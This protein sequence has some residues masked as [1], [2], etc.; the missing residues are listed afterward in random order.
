MRHKLFVSAFLVLIVAFTVSIAQAA[1]SARA[2]SSTFT[3]NST[4]DATDSNPGDDICETASGNGVCTLR[5]AIQ[6]TNALP[7]DD[8]IN[9]PAGS[10]TVTLTGMQEDG[11]ATGDFD[12]ADNVT[13]VGAGSA[14][15]IINANHLDRIFHIVTS[16]TVDLSGLT[17]KNGDSGSSSGGGILVGGT[18]AVEP[19]L[20]LTDVAVLNNQTSNEGG[21]IMNWFGTLMMTNVVVISNTATG[22]GAGINNQGVFTIT[23]S[24]IMSNVSNYRGGGIYTDRFA[25]SIISNTI[26]QSNFANLDGGGIYIFN[27]GILTLDS[28]M[29][30][31]NASLNRG[32][33]IYAAGPLTLTNST[34]AGNTAAQSGGGIGYYAYSLVILN[35]TISSNRASL[36]GGGVSGG[37]ELVLNNA[38]ITGNYADA[39][40]NGSGDGGGVAF[41]FGNSEI[42]NTIIAGNVDRGGEA[43]DCAGTLT[44]QDYNLIQDTTGCVL[45]GTV[46]HNKIGLNPQLGPLQDN[47]GSTFTHA[48]FFFSPAVDAGNNANCATSDQRGFVRPVDGDDDGSAICDIGA[49]EL[50]TVAVRRMYLPVILRTP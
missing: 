19:T 45:T 35:S 50:S 9:L 42:K 49:F 38:T 20:I 46:T 5:A 16:S 2:T 32:G 48:L 12:L 6:E 23:S 17:V 36:N 37:F 39:D 30:L 7:G 3:V 26:I 14:S 15:T 1:T 44:S 8:T 27:D 22:S 21:G 10:Y 47:G 33:G 25:P 11:S 40:S 18:A 28:S 29:V 31:S 13:I 34:I 41:P 43:P 4:I 24:T